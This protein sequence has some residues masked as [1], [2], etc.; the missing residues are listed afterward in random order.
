MELTAQ[1]IIKALGGGSAQRG[2]GRLQEAREGKIV[3]VADMR[4]LKEARGMKGRGVRISE[5]VASVMEKLAPVMLEEGWDNWDSLADLADDHY[6]D[7]GEANSA[8]AL[9]QLMRAGVQMFA[10]DLYLRTPVSWME[11]I[12]EVAS[13]KRMEFYAPLDQSLL[14]TQNRPQQPYKESK[15]TGSDIEVINNKYMGGE[16]FERELWDDDQ[17]GQIRTRANALGKGQRLIEEIFVAGRLM[18]LTNYTVANFVVPAS[19]WSG[20]NSVGTAITTPYSVDLFKPGSGNRPASYAQLSAITF[21]QGVAA[22][23]NA[24]DQNGIKIL[25]RPDHLIVSTQDA[26]NARTLVESDYWPAVQGLAGQTASNATA[27]A[28]AG[29]FA[30]NVFK[31]LVSFSVNYYMKDWAWN[32]MEKKAPA[33]VF[34]RRDPMEIVQENPLSGASFEQDVMRWRSRSRWNMEY[35]DPRFFWLGNDGSVAGSQ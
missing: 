33:S 6:M 24:L 12:P 31:G 25:V 7:M 11:Y 29:S 14:P 32:L 23:M 2:N 27:G 1:D 34:Q 20:Y 10:N 5:G 9:G 19:T 17:T 28:L 21:K 13:N 30:N 22:L 35:V 3:R 8:S 4:H 18:G 15:V 16:S 26:I